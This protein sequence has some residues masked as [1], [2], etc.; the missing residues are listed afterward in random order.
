[1]FMEYNIGQKFIQLSMMFHYCLL[2]AFSAHLAGGLPT[3][4]LALGLRQTPLG[5]P[6]AARPARG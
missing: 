6:T 1:M 4:A 3:A 5:G 2:R